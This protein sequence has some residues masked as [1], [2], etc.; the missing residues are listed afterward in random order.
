MK[1]R[2]VFGHPGRASDGLTALRP[3]DFTVELPSAHLGKNA[4]VLG[5]DKHFEIP[6]RRMGASSFSTEDGAM[7][8]IGRKPC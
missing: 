2:G 5:R 1:G 3:Q 7:K 4:P 6:E 8:P